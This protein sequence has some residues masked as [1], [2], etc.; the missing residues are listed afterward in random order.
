MQTVADQ[1]A[2]VIV[3]EGDEVDAP[4][5]PLQDE[6]EQVG[7]PE[8]VGPAALEAVD[9]GRVRP[10]GPLLRLIAG[11][12]QDVGDGLGAGGQGGATH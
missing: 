2:A 7:L 5:L 11:F 8:L 9:G 1:E 12:V 4:V 3:Q 6:G 10:G